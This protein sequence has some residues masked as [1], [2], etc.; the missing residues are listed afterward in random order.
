MEAGK[1]AWLRDSSS[2]GYSLR[3]LTR[4][5]GRWAGISGTRGASGTRR[6]GVAGRGTLVDSKWGRESESSGA[7][8]DNGAGCDDWLTPCGDVVVGE[9]SG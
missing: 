7:S 4:S 1:G 9:A 6:G 5:R 2:D 3:R 8:G